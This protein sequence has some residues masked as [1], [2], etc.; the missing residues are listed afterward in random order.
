VAVTG[1]VTGSGP[2][3]NVMMPPFVTAV[4]SAAKV[5]DAGVPVPTTVVGDEVSTS[6]VCVGRVKVVQEP[7][8]LPA[9]GNAPE[10]P[11]VVVDASEPPPAAS[12][13]PDEASEAVPPS[14]PPPLPPP[15]L[16][17]PLL[18]AASSPV[19]PPLPLPPPTPLLAPPPL[20]PLLPP[21]PSPLGDVPGELLHPA[22]IPRPR[23][24]GRANRIFNGWYA[25]PPHL[26]PWAKR[27]HGRTRPR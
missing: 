5:Q 16:P 1:M 18:L 9:E 24:Q 15:L 26:Q 13:A 7:F 4:F 25:A 14:V 17:A 10:S 20:P 3:S 11:L 12:C 19:E 21:P 22:A 23:R 2:Q 27:T 6:W 8:G